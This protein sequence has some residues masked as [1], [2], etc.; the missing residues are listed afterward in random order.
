MVLGKRSL[1]AVHLVDEQDALGGCMRE[2]SAYPNLGEWGRVITYRQVQLG[3]LQNVEVILNTRLEAED[4]FAY[5]AEIVVVATGARWRADGM[6]GPTQEAIPG[7]EQDFVYTPEQVSASKGAIDGEHVLVYD[8]DGYYTAVGVAELLL[9]AGKRVTIVTPLA[10]FASFMFFTGE[11]GP[12]NV[13]LR[14]RGAEIV[15]T[16]LLSEIADSGQRGQS[17]WGG[18]HVQWDADAVVLVTQRESNVGVYEELK[19]DPERLEREGIEA[20]YRVGDCVAPRMPAD[21]IFEGHRLAR[22]IDSAN[23]AVA[24]PFLRELPDVDREQSFATP[25]S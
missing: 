20:V 23:P 10:N 21:S 16:H 22:E 13:G 2:I 19:A 15:T 5:G 11:A 14:E 9:N 3:K 7:A 8:T 17:V 1:S 24:L 6:N 18:E 25:T 12:V 4:V